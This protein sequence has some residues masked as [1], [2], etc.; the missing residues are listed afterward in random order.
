MNIE[1]LS[2]DQMRVFA[3]AA[4]LG[5]LSA[6]AKKLARAQSA[7]S[8]AVTSLEEQLDT[9]LFDRSGHKPQLTPAGRALLQDVRVILA[10]S[11]RLL[12]RAQ[13]LQQE[14]EHEL[15][16]SIEVMFPV[17][18]L[19]RV[20]REF[21]SRF[22]QVN[23]RLY[24]EALGAVAQQ[25]LEG[26]AQ[27][28]VISAVHLPAVGLRSVALPHIRMVPVAAPSHP[29]AQ[30]GGRITVE[31]MQE[32]VQLVLTDRSTGTAGKD[33]MVFSPQTWRL[34]D[35]STKH[36]LLL[37][38]Q[39]FGT[40]PEH[41]VAEDMAAGRLQRLHLEPHPPEGELLSLACIHRL[42]AAVGP[43]MHWLIG[44]FKALESY[45]RA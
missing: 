11:D 33:F 31:Q 18:V 1:R 30:V 15:A 40:M 24:M 45:D 25:V 29:L 36:A 7:V 42:E 37:A 41:M 34:S 32:H 12:S 35:L 26:T 3:L 39:G 28:G 44:R 5:S 6:V 43:A 27:L 13:S 38:G 16:L 10:R 4:E 9:Q 22:P 21:R 17:T 20:L 14:T 8:Y 23:L 2:L 19:A